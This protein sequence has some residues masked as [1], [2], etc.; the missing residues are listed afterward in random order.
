MSAMSFVGAGVASWARAIAAAALLV[1]VIAPSVEAGLLTQY[2]P[3]SQYGTVVGLSPEG[4][5]WA[6]TADIE[7]AVFDGSAAALDLEFPGLF[8]Y[9]YQLF[10]SDSSY[11]P[12]ESF[13]VGLRPDQQAA[14][15]GYLDPNSDS[16]L[17]N[18]PG[19]A[20]PSSAIWN[21]NDAEPPSTT[22]SP[23]GHSAI[24][25]F[26]SPYGPGRAGAT[27]VG[28]LGA[29]VGEDVGPFS[30]APEPATGGLLM[31]GAIALLFAG[32]ARRIRRGKRAVL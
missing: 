11:Y 18:G 32:V 5:E 6:F 20:T 26:T 31:V 4:A 3:N 28:G 2:D 25:Y 7:Y 16:C 17:P 21:F 14:N 15:F 8:I 27:V 24:L 13:S 9:A 22:V 30:P 12:L 10:N 23:G 1:A 19:E 29:D